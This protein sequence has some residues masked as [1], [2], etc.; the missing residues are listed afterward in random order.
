MGMGMTRLHYDHAEDEGCTDW[1]YRTLPYRTGARI[2][3]GHDEGD[4][5]AWG[6]CWYEPTLLGRVVTWLRRR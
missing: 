4:D 2:V 3:H 6:T 1:C 5:C